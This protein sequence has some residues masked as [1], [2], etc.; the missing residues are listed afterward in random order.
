MK[1]STV[2]LIATAV[3]LFLVS[4]IGTA[5]VI[6]LLNSR[7]NVRREDLLNRSP[8]GDLQNVF[9]PEEIRE[10]EDRY[11][12]RLGTESG[13][14]S[15]TESNTGSETQP[16]DQSPAPEPYVPG[17]TI[18]IT[19]EVNIREGAGIAFKAIESK[20]P[21]T[22]GVITEAPQFADGYW[23]WAVDFE[24][25]ADGWCVQNAMS[26][27]ADT[28][29]AN[30]STESKPV[31]IVVHTPADRAALSGNS[32]TVSYAVSGDLKKAGAHYVTI[33]LDARPKTIRP[34]S[35]TAYTFSNVEPGPHSLVVVVENETGGEVSPRIMRTFTTSAP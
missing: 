8:F 32:F 19:N 34:L 24:S 5:M 22:V 26:K 29:G 11:H 2:R 1:P 20:Q 21:G 9:T 7:S 10:Q 18:A 23:W 33:T 16:S 17:D 4:I 35:S 31:S 14:P 25:G 6:R 30:P 27:F 3:F 15:T 28:P 12:G 13:A